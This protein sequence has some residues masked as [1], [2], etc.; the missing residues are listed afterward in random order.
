MVKIKEVTQDDKKVAILYY[1]GAVL[2][3]QQTRSTSKHAAHPVIDQTFANP[4]AILSAPKKLSV[5]KPWERESW[6]QP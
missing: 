2:D 5:K 3:G 1:R 4:H 6:K